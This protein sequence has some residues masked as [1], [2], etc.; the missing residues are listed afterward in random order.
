MAMHQ[1][2]TPTG[3][4]KSD[5]DIFSGISAKLG[6][7]QTFTAGLDEMGWIRK[8]YR[9]T[10]EFAKEQAVEL[11]SF[12]DFWS[13]GEFEFTPPASDHCM[14]SAFRKSPEDDPLN[15]PSGKI[16]IFSSIIDNYGYLDCPGHP[17]WIPPTEWLG[18]KIADKFPYHLTSNQPTT[19]LHSQLDN[20]VTS[21]KSKVASREPLMIHPGDAAKKGLSNGDVVRV[22]NA[23]GAL[24][25]GVVVSENVRQGVLQ[26][27]TGAWWDPAEWGETR[28][29]CKHGNVNVLTMDKGTSQLAQGPSAL[30]CL[31]DIE[32]LETTPPEVSAYSPPEIF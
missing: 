19:R 32:R 20:G 30:S 11:P 16:E 10:Q 13:T 26:M 15:T 8:L 3:Q 14:M 9:L 25:A 4:A 17:V 29:I 5:F 7:E 1:A 6:T 24:L 12:E 18:N 27:A 31:V 22:F 2:C 21:Q 23:R 28:E